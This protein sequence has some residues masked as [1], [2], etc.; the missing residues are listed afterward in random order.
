MI[1]IILGLIIGFFY[2]F[3]EDDGSFRFVFLDSVLGLLIGLVIF[4]T[5][6]KIIGLMLPT[7]DTVEEHKLYAL[8]DN[9]AT[10]GE[11]FLSS[12]YVKEELVYRYVI[13]TE[14][15][16]HVEE[17]KADN[18]Y[19]K[20]G[21]Y[22]PVVKKHTN[23]FKRNWYYWFGCPRFEREGYTEFYVPRNTITNE[24]NIDLK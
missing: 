6:G 3:H 14:K 5:I 23:E 10:Q 4:L 15:G 11:F 7:V 19:I 24:Y 21:D 18:A 1:F 12:G 8:N 16:K 17:D 9:D 13:D 20:E 2:G 22:E